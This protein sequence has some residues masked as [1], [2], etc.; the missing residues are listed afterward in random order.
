MGGKKKVGGEENN[1]KN[2]HCQIFKILVT[3]F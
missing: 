3:S 1:D 2:M